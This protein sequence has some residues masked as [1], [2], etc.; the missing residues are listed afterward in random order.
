[1]DDLSDIKKDLT[2]VNYPAYFAPRPVTVF[3]AR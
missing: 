3:V 2:A 1:M